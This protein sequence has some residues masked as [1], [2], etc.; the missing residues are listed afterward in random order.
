MRE[1]E[2]AQIEREWGGVK[3]ELPS[4]PSLEY[5][6][7]QVKILGWNFIKK[8]QKFGLHSSFTQKE[9]EVIVSFN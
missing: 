4:W 3:N 6:I 1:R 5:E 9:V 8:W 2:R 7:V